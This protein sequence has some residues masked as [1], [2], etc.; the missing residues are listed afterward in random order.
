MSF[1]DK[2][3]ISVCVESNLNFTLHLVLVSFCW[4]SL[5]HF[6]RTKTKRKFEDKANIHCFQKRKNTN[7]QNSLGADF[8]VTAHWVKHF[9]SA[10]IVHSSLDIFDLL[11]SL[12]WLRGKQDDLLLLQQKE[13]NHT[14]AS[15]LHKL[16]AQTH[17]WNFNGVQMF[18]CTFG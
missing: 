2:K 18:S 4:P 10:S 17:T 12:F 3:E 8:Q 15:V 13:K 5:C 7:V 16:T 6:S 1:N 9:H 11:R 14:L